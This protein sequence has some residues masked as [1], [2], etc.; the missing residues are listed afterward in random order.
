MVEEKLTYS[1]PRMDVVIE[2][3]PSGRERT[4]ATFTIET[5]AKRGQRAVRTTVN[6]KTG[7]DNAPKALTYAPK[8]RFVDGS[9]GRLYVVNLSPYSNTISVMKGTFDYSHETI[10]AEDPRHGAI[11][12]LFNEV[13]G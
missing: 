11:L 9:D 8:V 1:N 4:K 12:A 5:H 6:P 13:A 7:R 2:D 3:W 10:Y